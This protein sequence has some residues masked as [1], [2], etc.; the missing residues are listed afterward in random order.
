MC[1]VCCHRNLT[2][3]AA[4]CEY[5][6]LWEHRR[7][8]HGEAADRRYHNLRS[9]DERERV[10][11]AKMELVKEASHQTIRRRSDEPKLEIGDRISIREG[12]TGMVLARYTP[13]GGKNEV[14]YIVELLSNRGEKCAP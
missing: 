11:C 3:S 1:L 6:V 5:R 14:C 9:P 4:T 8:D 2:Q 12:V 10:E 7:V 13:S